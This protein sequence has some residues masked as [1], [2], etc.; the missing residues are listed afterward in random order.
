MF[1]YLGKTVNVVIDR[2]LGSTHPK[3]KFY[4]PINYGYIPNTIAGDG[5]EIDAYVLGEYEPLETYQGKV[6]AVIQRTNDNEDKLVVAKDMNSFT[7]QQV[8]A[9][10]Q[11][12]ERFFESDIISFD[13]FREKI[14]VT[15]KGI[16]RRGNKILVIEEKEDRYFRLIGGGVE[17]MEKTH[18]TLVREF[19]EEINVDIKEYKFI[20]VI[21]NIF[22]FKEMNMHE[23]CF[24]YEVVLSDEYYKIEEYDVTADI[25][26][27]KAKWIDKE[28]FLSK[29]EKLLPEEILLYL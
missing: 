24:L 11:F 2:P 6:I 23:L 7:S 21:E 20:D 1:E 15:A 17:F 14:R 27:S 26:P 28:K 12:Q 3:H 4:Y 22:C 18:E 13:M 5:E 19:K 8:I 25:I 9:L 29:N 10:T 16:V